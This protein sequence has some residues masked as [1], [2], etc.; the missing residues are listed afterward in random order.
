[1]TLKIIGFSYW[2]RVLRKNNVPETDF[3]DHMKHRSNNFCHA[4]AITK[5]LQK[6]FYKINATW[7]SQVCLSIRKLKCPHRHRVKSS[8][9]EIV[10]TLSSY[11][12]ISSCITG[13]QMEQID[14]DSESDTET[15]EEGEILEEPQEY[16]EY[17]DDSKIKQESEE[18]EYYISSD[19]EYEVNSDK[20]IPP[21]PKNKSVTAVV[22]EDN[23]NGKI[24]HPTPSS[25]VLLKCCF[26]VSRCRPKNI[27]N[28]LKNVHKDETTKNPNPVLRECLNKILKKEW[29]SNWKYWTE[30]KELKKKISL[31]PQN[32]MHKLQFGSFPDQKSCGRRHS[33][34][35]F[36]GAQGLQVTGAVDRQAVAVAGH[37]LCKA[38]FLAARWIG[39]QAVAGNGQFMNTP[40]QHNGPGPQQHQPLQHYGHVL[41]QQHKQLKHHGHVLQQNQPLQVNDLEN[42]RLGLDELRLKL[43]SINSKISLHMRP[44]VDQKLMS[45]LYQQQYEVNQAIQSLY[46]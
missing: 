34:E 39:N 23:Q 12:N 44:P 31:N 5:H 1:M 38:L 43:A 42:S 22:I 10:I 24:S 30:L 37:V 36:Q 32:V 40:L 16:I 21:Y 19:S 25:K 15:V 8:R 33:G 26:C 18:M 28:H 27:L 9:R 7:T 45:E 20:V 17:D 46:Y 14:L 41:K 35:N 4:L 3:E 11:Q 13:K 29:P 6:A 2:R